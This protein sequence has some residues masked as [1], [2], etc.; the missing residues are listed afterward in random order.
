MRL[1]L[2]INTHEAGYVDAYFGPGEWKV[3][4]EANPR[5]VS[6]LKAAAENFIGMLRVR[7]GERYGRNI[8]R[9]RAIC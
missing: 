6:T 5:D 2:E 8:A 4:A 1:A 9:A 3:Q 7:G